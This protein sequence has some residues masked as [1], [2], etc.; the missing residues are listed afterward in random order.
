MCT[1]HFVFGDVESG[2]TMRLEVKKNL[3]NFIIL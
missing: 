2:A 3:H 1:G